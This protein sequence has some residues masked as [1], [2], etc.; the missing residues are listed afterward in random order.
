MSTVTD[1]TE[2]TQTTVLAGSGTSVRIRVNASASAI[3]GEGLPTVVLFGK[4]GTKS[5][6]LSPDN[7]IMFAA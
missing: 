7:R 1:T 2:T 6:A 3:S 5:I 4:S